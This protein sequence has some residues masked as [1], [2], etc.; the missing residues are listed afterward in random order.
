MDS[1]LVKNSASSRDPA[2]HGF[3]KGSHSMNM[4][5]FP[6]RRAPWLTA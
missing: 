6:K 5:R 3:C 4:L 1:R 2:L